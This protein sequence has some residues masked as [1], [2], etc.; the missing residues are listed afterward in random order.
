MCPGGFV[1]PVAVNSQHVAVNGMSTA[2]RNSPWA[3]AGIVVEIQPNDLN[4]PL[5][6]PHNDK[7]ILDKNSPLALMLL[8]EYLE[9]LAWNAGGQK[10]SAPAQ[11]MM[12]FLNEKTSMILPKSS[13]TP[14]LQS[15][16]LHELL[17]KFVAERLKNGFLEF[18]RVSKGFLTNEALMIGI[19]TRTSA[20]VRILRNST[21]CQ[22]VRLKNLFPCGEG[23]GYAGGIVSAAIDGRRCADC[24][25]P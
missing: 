15:Y 19:E 18:N 20:P 17:P 23:A 5:L 16:P 12:D 22:H 25:P 21:T 2:K 13:Y 14:G 24:V 9:T 6:L 3:N 8:Q 7:L 1:V 11:K 4:D 10:Q